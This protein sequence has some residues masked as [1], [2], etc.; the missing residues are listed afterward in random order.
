MKKGKGKEAHLCHSGHVLMEN[1]HGLCVD[2]AVDAADG[3]AERRSVKTMLKDVR[4]RHKLKPKTLGLDAGY[5]DG[6]FLHELEHEKIIPHVPLR[7]DRVVATDEG[8]LAR[9]RAKQRQK[10]KGYKT[11]QRIRK[12]VEE[13]FGWL[14][15]IAGLARTRFVG[16]WKIG[17]Q[18]LIASAAYNLLRMVRLKPVA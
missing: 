14:K 2:V 16:R 7:T 17:Q 11:S 8:G 6:V 13:I 1:R 15:T 12:R 10:T 9:R 3:H 4:K 5:D 18:M